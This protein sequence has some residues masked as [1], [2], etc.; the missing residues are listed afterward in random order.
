M[1]TMATKRQAVGLIEMWMDIIHRLIDGFDDLRFKTLI[2]REQPKEEIKLILF[3]IA[4]H[5]GYN[6]DFVPCKEKYV[7]WI[8]PIP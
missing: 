6:L 2:I 7:I 4:N 3:E 1:T 5:R 8:E